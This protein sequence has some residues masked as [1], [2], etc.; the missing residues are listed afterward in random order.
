MRKSGSSVKHLAL[1]KKKQ[2]SLLLEVLETFLTP[3]LRELESQGVSV[4]SI[5]LSNPD[6]HQMS[7][8]F[9]MLTKDDV[10][11]RRNCFKLISECNA[12]LKKTDLT[13]WWL[14]ETNPFMLSL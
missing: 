10:T 8:E 11:Q 2:E 9:S 3:C 1:G 6:H 13:W 7:L 5:T 4:T 14:L 12:R